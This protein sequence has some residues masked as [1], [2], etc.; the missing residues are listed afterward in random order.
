M[1]S[2]QNLWNQ[3]LKPDKRRRQGDLASLRRALWFAITASE[4]GMRDAMAAGNTDEFRKFVHALNQL[5]GTYIR[6]TLDGD[7]EARLA[8]I[9]AS[10][11]TGGKQTYEQKRYRKEAGR[12]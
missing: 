6:C 11:N 3:L 12:D 4:A 10:L 9:E 5:G 2:G 1:P 8:R 7:L